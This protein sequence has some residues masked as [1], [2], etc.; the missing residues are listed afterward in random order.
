MSLN[1][2]V[3]KSKLTESIQLSLPHRL[4][5]VCDEFESIDSIPVIE[6]GSNKLTSYMQQQ[7]SHIQSI[8]PWS[9][10]S[11]SF[12]GFAT[13]LA[14]DESQL[15][16]NSSNS[17]LQIEREIMMKTAANWQNRNEMHKQKYL[18]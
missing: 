18:R 6:A 8:S 7:Q 10:A 5:S 4:T 9:S 14:I 1:V 2:D 3:D 15:N 16:F 12:D 11:S 13:T 17:F